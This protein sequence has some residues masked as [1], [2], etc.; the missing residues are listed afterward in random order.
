[1]QSGPLSMA[2]EKISVLI[3]ASLKRFCVSCMED[4]FETELISTVA[5][6][7]TYVRL[8]PRDMNHFSFRE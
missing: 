4:F 3:S 1:M 7:V 6:F 8:S 5:F 2:A